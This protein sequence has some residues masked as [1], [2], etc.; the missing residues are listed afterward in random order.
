L[1]LYVPR[2]VGGHEPTVDSG[3]GS[4]RLLD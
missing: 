2:L 3:R 4:S 1:P